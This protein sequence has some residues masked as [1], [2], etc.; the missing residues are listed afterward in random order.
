MIQN[1]V[2]WA[3]QHHCTL[4]L[5][6]C[7]CALHK[8]RAVGTLVWGQLRSHHPDLW[9][10]TDDEGKRHFRQ[11]RSHCEAAPNLSPSSMPL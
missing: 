10:L 4:E 1:T 9:Q 2:F 6:V 3:W 11:W 8:I 5:L 7:A